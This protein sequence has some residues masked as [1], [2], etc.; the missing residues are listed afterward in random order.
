MR[1]DSSPLSQ[2]D[3]KFADDVR[4]M[5]LLVNFFRI[6][7]AA[8][9]GSKPVA[10]ANGSA[11]S[12]SVKPAGS[13]GGGGGG[14]GGG[15]APA[16]GGSGAAPTSSK[17]YTLTFGKRYQINK[18]GKIGSGSFGDIY[19][20]TALYRST[21]SRHDTT[22]HGTNTQYRLDLSICLFVCV[23]ID[24]VTGEAVAVKLEAAKARHRQLAAEFDIYQQLTPHT[25]IP[26]VRWFGKEGDYYIMV[27]DL[28]GQNL[29]TL[30]NRCNRKLSLK[31][32]LMLGDQMISRLEYMHMK[33]YLHR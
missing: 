16:S 32:I 30:F 1:R 4:T 14:G 13:G 19:E 15:A 9:N 31:T 10:G 33:N 21:S 18:K 29:E 8:T 24:L 26:N 20:G 2:L 6:A 22:R 27:M 7:M 17:N 5:P 23:G 12:G 28:L 3:Q 11:P 25:G